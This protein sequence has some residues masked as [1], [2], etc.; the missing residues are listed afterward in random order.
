MLRCARVHQHELAVE[1][2]GHQGHPRRVRHHER[3]PGEKKST[4]S[5]P[6][7]CYPTLPYLKRN[8][9]HITN[10]FRHQVQ[11]RTFAPQAGFGVS[12]E[13]EKGTGRAGVEIGVHVA[14]SAAHLHVQYTRRDLIGCASSLARKTCPFRVLLGHPPPGLYRSHQEKKNAVRAI[15]NHLL[16]DVIECL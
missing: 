12:T 7:L 10:P 8:T 13:A 14:S 4:L 1:P 6:I 2:R 11:K 5:C 15:N 16:L 9:F 3:G